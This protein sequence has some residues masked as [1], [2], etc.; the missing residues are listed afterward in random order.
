MPVGLPPPRSRG[1][2]LGRAGALRG[3]VEAVGLFFS[4]EG[5][6]LTDFALDF[7]R[8]RVIGSL[9]LK[10]GAGVDEADEGRLLLAYAMPSFRS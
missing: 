7:E 10:L 1:A 6:D 8:E 2:E 9:E 5:G 3:W 4:M